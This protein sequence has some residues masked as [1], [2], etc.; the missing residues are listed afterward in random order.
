MSLMTPEAFVRLNEMN[1]RLR[2]GLKQIRQDLK[3][4]G[5]VQ[6]EGSLSSL[7]MTDMPLENYRQLAA[8]MASG[9]AVK[10]EKYNRMLLEEGV[11]S[12]RGGFIGS[13][14][15]TEGDIDFTLGAVRRALTRLLVS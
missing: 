12:M 11:F 2:E 8:A 6:G 9:L 14:A 10:I 7:M 5:V 13:T 1:Q 3:I 4:V 15:M